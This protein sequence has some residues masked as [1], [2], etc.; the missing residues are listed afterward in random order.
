MPKL[1]LELTV[2][3]AG[4]VANGL[5]A[6][7]RLCI[8]QLGEVANLVRAGIIPMAQGGRGGPRTE[9]SPDVCDA[10][11]ALMN[12]VKTLLGYPVNGNHGIGHPHVALSALRAYEVEKVLKK[13]VIEHRLP[14]P[15]FKG[16]D[17]DGLGPRYTTDPA[18]RALISEP[19]NEATDE[20][21]VSPPHG[22]AAD[23]NLFLKRD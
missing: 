12:Q 14:N 5:D 3:Q 18:P 22:N 15:A 21:D 17:Y 11:E 19:G 9:A 16:V 2:D 23:R 13:A 6:Y 1:N 4:A 8:G 7:V 10:V 20:A